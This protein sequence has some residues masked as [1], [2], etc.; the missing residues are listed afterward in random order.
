MAG[1]ETKR[2]GAAGWRFLV[3]VAGTANKVNDILAGKVGLV[4]AD[5]V[6]VPELLRH[7]SHPPGAQQLTG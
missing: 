7:V 6:R 5:A 2:P 3:F 4:I 1:C